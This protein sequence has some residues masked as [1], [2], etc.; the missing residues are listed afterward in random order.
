METIIYTRQ[1]MDRTGEELAVSRQ[2]EDGE[3]LASLRGWTV[4]RTLTDNDTSAAGRK[5]RPGFDELIKALDSGEA[6]AVI[7]WD[8]TRLERNRRDGLRLIETCQRNSVTLAFVRGADIDLSTPAGR[9]VADMLSGVARHEID[10]KSDRQRRAVEQAA[11]DGRWVSGRKPFGYENDGVTVR[12]DEARAI[13][14]GYDAFLAGVSLN[15]IARNWNSRGFKG[16]SRPWVWDNVRTVLRNPR[17]AGFRAHRKEIVGPAKWPAIISEETWRAAQDVF[18]QRSARTVPRG[19]QRL[20]TAIAVCGACSATVHAGGA[21]GKYPMYRCSGY[22]TAPDRKAMP[23][24]TPHVSRQALQAEDYVTAVVIERLSRPDAVDLLVDTNRPDVHE[25]RRE[26][27]ALRAKLERHRIDYED[28]TFTKAEYLNA[29]ERT[30]GK[31]AKIEATLADAGRVDVLGPLVKAGDVRAVWESLPMGHRRM[32]IDTLMT[33]RL[34]SPG[35][36]VRTFRP[37][38]VEILWK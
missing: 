4:V 2:R 27:T 22:L 30:L 29:K 32:V 6:K 9:L 3:Q 26:A 31:I 25:L 14:D 36:G 13:R 33:I 23:S 16:Q 17:Y 28:D 34:H 10:Q 5:T 35:R 20:L 7:A 37:E 11:K 12:P 24:D 18:D 15:E 19:A 1:S 8:W 38:T 21:V